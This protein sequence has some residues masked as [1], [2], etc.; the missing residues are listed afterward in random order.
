MWFLLDKCGIIDLYATFQVIIAACMKF[1]VS[2][3][4]LPCSEV[5]VDQ[6]FKLIALMMEAVRTPETLVNINLTTRQYIPGDSKLHIDLYFVYFL[7]L[8]YFIQ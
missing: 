4:V 6:C 1:R 7:F 3:D 2:W 5:D 8:V